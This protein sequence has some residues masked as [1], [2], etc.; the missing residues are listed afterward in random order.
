M[1]VHELITTLQQFN[2]NAEVVGT[3]EGQLEDIS[4]YR[5]ADGR[6]LVDVDHEH[7]RV[8][9]QKTP[10][11]VCG[12]QAQGTPCIASKPVCYEHWDT[13]VTEV[14]SR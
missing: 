14:E 7:Y 13:F 11:E 6:I 10:C 4:V 1:R 3:W 5:A 8:R 2:A 12:K 9:F